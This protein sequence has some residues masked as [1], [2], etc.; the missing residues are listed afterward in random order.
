MFGAEGS[1]PTMRF[2]NMREGFGAS[3]MQN[4]G[5]GNAHFPYDAGAAQTWNSN[6]GPL[7]SFG[8]GMGTMPQNSNYGPSRSVKPSRGRVGV[9][10]VSMLK[11]LH[12]SRY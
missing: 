5:A 6:G 2:D 7:Q 8:N 11:C 3:P 4:P 10:N 1:L 12:D 9:S